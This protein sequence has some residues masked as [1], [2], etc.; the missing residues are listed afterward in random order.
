MP[1]LT[2]YA[3]IYH[4]GNLNGTRNKP[5]FSH[6][7]RGL[8]VSHH[9]RDWKQIAGNVSGDQYELNNP[10]ATFYEV[11]PSEMPT[12]EYRDWALEHDYACEITAFK[13][14]TGDGEHYLFTDKERA[15]TEAWEHNTD[16][17]ETT[18]VGLGPKGREYWQEAFEKDPELASPVAVKGLLVVWYAEHALPVDVD[19]VWWQYNYN[20]QNLSCPCGVIF[21]SQLDDW[22]YRKS[23]EEPFQNTVTPAL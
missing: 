22:Q 15:E 10:D 17:I 3:T 4:V 1:Q 5:Y 21:Q 20:P 16:V 8:C 7:G 6:E 19:G 2:N 9:P 14:P 13:V 12:D 18:S 11:R 23:D